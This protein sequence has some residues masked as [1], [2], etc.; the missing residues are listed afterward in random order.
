MAEK[1]STGFSDEE[2]AAMKERALELKAEA[3]RGRIAADGES[4]LLR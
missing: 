3:R 4:D 1:K 2:R